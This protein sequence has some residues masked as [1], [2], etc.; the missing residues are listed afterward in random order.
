MYE[1]S[2]SCLLC[3]VKYRKEKK[4]SDPQN[5]E[6]VSEWSGKKCS[7]YDVLFSNGVNFN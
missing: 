5:H 2:Q 7:K 4:N 1:K 6:V 3:K